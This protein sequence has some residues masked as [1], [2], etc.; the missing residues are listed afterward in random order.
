MDFTPISPSFTWF[1][2]YKPCFG[3]WCC[4]TKHGSTVHQRP[5]NTNIFVSTGPSARRQQLAVTTES[6]NNINLSKALTNSYH[7][8]TPLLHKAHHAHK[9]TH[10]Q[11][12]MFVSKCVEHF[13]CHILNGNLREKQTLSKCDLCG[14][15]GVHVHVCVA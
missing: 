10:N 14:G 13:M 3:L 7:N 8:Y 6:Q 12:H 2:F 4:S 11:K 9:T 15:E 1:S 5:L